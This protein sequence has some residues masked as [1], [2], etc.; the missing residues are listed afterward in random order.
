MLKFCH[1]VNQFKNRSSC[2]CP[3]AVMTLEHHCLIWEIAAQ[4]IIAKSHSG[5]APRP[6][7]SVV[8][9]LQ[10]GVSWTLGASCSALGVALTPERA[11]IGS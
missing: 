7:G 10:R 1:L 8:S 4:D 2:D 3:S 9:Q 5:L 11:L 6:R